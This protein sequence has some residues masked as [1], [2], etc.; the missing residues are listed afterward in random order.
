MDNLLFIE[1]LNSWL[2]FAY[3]IHENLSKTGIKLKP[4]R[5]GILRSIKV[6]CNEDYQYGAAVQ[7]NQ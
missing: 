7:I 1:Q 2:I 3:E 5:A 6:Q 4:D